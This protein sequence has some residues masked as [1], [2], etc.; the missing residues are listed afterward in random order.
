LDACALVL[1]C[2]RGLVE[3]DELAEQAASTFAMARHAAVDLAQLFRTPPRKVVAR[4]GRLPPAERARLRDRL[5]AVGGAPGPE[6][7]GGVEGRLDELR[8]LYDPSMEGWAEYLLM[9]L[10]LWVPA[11]GTLDDWQTTADGVTAPALATLVAHR[12]TA[13]TAA[14]D[15]VG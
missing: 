2:R 5:A 13:A 4:D 10:P 15:Q 11:P 12:R 14:A 3:D 7:G 1:A 8:A 9:A 6:K